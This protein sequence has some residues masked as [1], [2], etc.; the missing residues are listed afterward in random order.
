MTLELREKLEKISS[1]LVFLKESV[2]AIH[3]LPLHDKAD[4]EAICGFYILFEETIRELE[5][6]FRK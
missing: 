4:R 2:G 6:I 3:E 5:K 1:K